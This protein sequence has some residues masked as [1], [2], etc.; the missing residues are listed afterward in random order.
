MLYAMQRRYLGGGPRGGRLPE[1]E[2]TRPGMKGDALPSVC[3]PA[4]GLAGVA[5][6]RGHGAARAAAGASVGEEGTGAGRGGAAGAPDAPG[7]RAERESR[8]AGVARVAAADGGCA[9]G[10]APGSGGLAKSER[11][12][13]GAPV[14]KAGERACQQREQRLFHLLDGQGLEE[15][16]ELQR[17]Q[18]RQEKPQPG[19]TDIGRRGWT[20]DGSSR[21]GAGS[22]TTDRRGGCLRGGGLPT[23]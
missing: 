1:S 13:R 9:V 18:H 22:P 16:R 4:G 6:R 7:S 20:Q 5:E 10:E 3:R 21:R 14:S 12:L 19:V 15:S 2:G 17:Q 11:A 23:R 8:A